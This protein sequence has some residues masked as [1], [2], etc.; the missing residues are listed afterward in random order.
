MLG[1]IH[2][3]KQFHLLK[4]MMRLNEKVKELIG[5]LE[6][7]PHDNGTSWKKVVDGKAEE[8]REEWKV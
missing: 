4:C 3:M 2:R 8:N 1:H 7:N 6:G 5:K